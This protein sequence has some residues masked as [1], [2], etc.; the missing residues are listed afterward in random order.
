[1]I[2][3]I[4][5]VFNKETYLKST[6]ESILNQNYC[7][8]ELILIDGG[9]IDNSIEVISEFDD[10]R[11]KLIQL[12]NI[13]IAGTR[14]FGVLKSKYN[15]CAFIDADDHWEKDYLREIVKLISFRPKN[16]AFATGYRRV[17]GD[18]IED[19]QYNK[20]KISKNLGEY[21]TKR[22]FGW[23]IHTSSVV[24]NKEELIK[25]GGFPML[26]RDSEDSA[27]IL[28]INGKNIK[29][30]PMELCSSS[31]WSIFD[32]TL[33]N[34]NRERSY[35][36]SVPGIP[37][38]DQYL[39]DLTGLNEENFVYTNTIL[40]SWRGD[41]RNQATR[42][43]R[44]LP[45]YPQLLILSDVK[46]NEVTKYRFYLIADLVM[47][48]RRKEPNEFKRIIQFH[49]SSI[50]L[51]HKI[52]HKSPSYLYKISLIFI[53]FIYRIIRKLS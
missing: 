33:L 4:C 39:W 2:S 9:S 47:Q 35:F 46:R 34:L 45:I 7:Q 20:N 11:I 42:N 36:I 50:S 21:F 37:G 38:E 18:K 1:M 30:V 19:V 10:N 41:V 31:I 8:F 17:Y 26:V 15:Y 14:N 3:I 13:G 28:D 22:L 32:T 53:V 44:R 16:I 24:Y 52:L 5:P 29:S 25:L 12:P 6:I 23:G 48:I 40:S 43:P 49:L 27:F 51:I